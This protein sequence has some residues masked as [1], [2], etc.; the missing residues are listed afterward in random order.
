MG[1]T[2]SYK[3]MLITLEDGS[4][5]VKKKKAKHND[6]NN[7]SKHQFYLIDQLSLCDLHVVGLLGKGSFGNVEHVRFAATSFALK[8]IPKTR[9]FTNHDHS[10]LVWNERDILIAC[11]SPFILPVEC[12]FQTKDYILILCPYYAGGDLLDRIQKNVEKGMPPKAHTAAFYCAELI[13]ALEHMHALNICHRDVKPDNCFLDEEGH[14]VLGDLGMAIKIKEGSSPEAVRTRKWGRCGSYGYRSPEVLKNEECGF[15]SDVY[16]LGITM[17]FFLFGGVPWSETKIRLAQERLTKTTSLYFPSNGS[18][19]NPK[20]KNLLTRMLEVNPKRRITV[21][22]MKAHSLFKWVDWK[23]LANHHVTPPWVPP[24][25]KSTQIMG[26]P[27]ALLDGAAEKAGAPPLTEP[28]QRCFEGFEYFNVLKI[29]DLPLLSLPGTPTASPPRSTKEAKDK[30]FDSF[31]LGQSHHSSLRDPSLSLASLTSDS[32]PMVT[33]SESGSLSYGSS[34]CLTPPSEARS[35]THSPL[36]N[37]LQTGS[38]TPPKHVRVLGVARSPKKRRRS[39]LKRQGDLC[40]LQGAINSL[41]ASRDRSR[42]K[43]RSLQFY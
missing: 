37:K 15:P 18:L 32:G 25:Q 4:S 31:S 17:Y 19:A 36:K 8:T 23:E 28:Q 27:Y 10:Q 38:L 24:P 21:K 39:L 40:K 7:S 1:N 43:A 35:P 33:L 3:D 14:I 30:G 11:D 9:L 6:G 5:P 34:P 41:H 26:K 2:S 13:L 42:L 16:S 29:P 20:F 12:C 22:Q